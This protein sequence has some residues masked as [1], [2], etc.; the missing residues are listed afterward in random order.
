VTNYRVRQVLALGDDMPVR[1]LRFMVALAT[2]LGDDSR[3][4]RIGFDALTATAR[5]TRRNMKLA[6]GELRDSGRI[7]YLPGKHRGDLTLW[8]ALCLPERGSPTGTSFEA[9]KG[10]PYG[11]ERGSPG[12]E[13]GGPRQDADQQK[14][15][16]SL[17]RQAKP[18]GSLSRALDALADAVPTL[19]E[20]EI[21]SI[22]DRLKD[23]PE[24]PHPGPY[25]HA[26]ISNGD[27]AAFADAI[28]NGHGRR[29]R[30]GR[31]AETDELF[32]DALARAR[33]LDAAEA[34][35]RSEA[36]KRNGHRDCA[37]GSAWC[38]CRC[39]QGS[40]RERLDDAQPLAAITA[41]VMQRT[42]AE[43]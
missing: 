22:T 28:L 5:L 16:H 17:N 13:K 30:H 9:Q 27:A 20:K 8:I 6:R 14:P 31:Q 19:T 34:G 23:N 36:C 37:Y 26:V 15:E 4:V 25:L 32:D 21:E 12:T 3:Q 10:V 2:Y 41:G 40:P 43:S 1:H 39:H 38:T 29:G 42:G 33:A 11:S 35:P 24:I 7:D 18:S